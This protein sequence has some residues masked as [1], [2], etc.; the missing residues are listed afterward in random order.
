MT[1][2]FARGIAGA[3]A[4]AAGAALLTGCFMVPGEFESEMTVAADGSFTYSY[5]GE[6]SL[7]GLTQLAEMAEGASGASEDSGIDEP[8]YDWPWDVEENT[9]DAEVPDAA[10]PSDGT[11]KSRSATGAGQDATI[12]SP[13]PM[14]SIRDTGADD[15]RVEREC[16][17][18]ELAERRERAEARRQSE[19]R[20]MRQMSALFGGID[21]TDPDAGEEIAA[22]LRR[23]QGW[24]SVEY[25][26]NGVFD[27]D[28]SVTSRLTHSFAFPMIESM[29]TAQPFVYAYRR[30]D[31]IRIEA[32][33]FAISK[34]MAGPMGGQGG[35]MSLL[36]FASMLGAE[37]GMDEEAEAMMRFFEDMGGTF[38][39]TVDNDVLANNTLDG[40][41][42]LPDGRRRMVWT[43]DAQ[44]DTAPMALIAM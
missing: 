44:T 3:V 34:S 43:I 35:G 6:I 28:Y 26:G 17:P 5:D 11:D 25:S 42:R 20:Q 37:G 16:T 23:Q 22:R 12:P 14:F 10:A 2:Q 4:A 8:C 39:L 24:N 18:Q 21:P 1:F 30:N 31:A 27:V 33:G 7:L 41:E 13:P 36:M 15:D 40:F 29:S 38:T 9:D 19:E 32:P